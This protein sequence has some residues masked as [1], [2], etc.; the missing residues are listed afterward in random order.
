[1]AAGCSIARYGTAAFH[2]RK[3]R[4]DGPA[5]FCWSVSLAAREP[6]AVQHPN[7]MLFVAGGVFEDWR[8]GSS[9]FR[10]GYSWKAHGLYLVDVQGELETFAPVS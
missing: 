6:M 1:M 3:A 9:D 5:E 2:R 4:A 8:S 10:S 7:G